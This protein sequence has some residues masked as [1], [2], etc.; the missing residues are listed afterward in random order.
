MDWAKKAE[1]F[2]KPNWRK[3][4]SSIVLFVIVISFMS[5][6]SADRALLMLG[7]AYIY[8]CRLDRKLEKKEL[9]SPMAIIID[10]LV[11]FIIVFLGILALEKM[12]SVLL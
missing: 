9:H 7:L 4:F 12:F 2:L 3:F 8:S 6:L 10:L 11:F 1:K 5:N